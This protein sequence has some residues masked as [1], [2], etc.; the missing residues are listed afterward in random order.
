MQ[1]CAATPDDA[2]PIA[3]AQVR[4][5]QAAYQGM[6]PPDYLAALSVARRAA[7]WR[8]FIARGS[9]ELLVAKDG[10]C[11]VGFV[12]FGRC[13]DE[14]AVAAQAEIWAIYVVPSHWSQGVGAALWSAARRR[15]EEQGYETVSLWVLTGNDRAIRFYSGVGF[16]PQGASVKDVIIGGAVLQ[17]VRYTAPLQAATRR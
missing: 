16:E 12:A 8:E 11:V 10:E 1:I 13:R 7:L 14:D 2:S 6:L 9:P 3:H 15:L 4:S 17:E 5:W